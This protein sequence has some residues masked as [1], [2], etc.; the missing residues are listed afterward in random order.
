MNRNKWCNW[1]KSRKHK[2]YSKRLKAERIKNKKLVKKY[3]WLKPYQHFK[4]KHLDSKYDYSYINWGF[5]NGWNIAFGDMFMKELGEAVKG[6]K[7]FGILQTKEKYGRLCCYTTGTTQKA[8]D[9][10][11]KY[12]HI[13]RYVCVICGK[14]DVPTLNTGWISPECFD[15]FVKSRQRHQPID[16]EELWKQYITY[17]EMHEEYEW[18]I[19]NTYAY[20]RWDK[21]N[22]E[23][24]VTHDISETVKAVRE[25]YERRK[26]K[27]DKRV[28]RNKHI[29]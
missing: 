2:K 8:H 4:K 25:R 20:I 28:L 5:T 19:P 21:N 10:I 15:C 7:D 6:Q 3:P 16:I 13:S 9:I 27:Y 23:E 12:E 14:P 26:Q 18:K 17:T 22:N 24:T 1:F 29:T 11:D